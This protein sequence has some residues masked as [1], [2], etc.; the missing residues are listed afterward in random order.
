M[1]VL[2]CKV[3]TAARQITIR[4]IFRVRKRCQTL[5]SP[6][7]NPARQLLSRRPSRRKVLASGG[8]ENARRRA[9]FRARFRRAFALSS[10]SNSTLDSYFRSR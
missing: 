9:R 3:A 7:A 4:S 8:H 5:R 10:Y 2:P 1:D 6:V